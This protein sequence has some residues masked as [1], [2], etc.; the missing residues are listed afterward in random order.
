MS[1]QIP[2]RTY[3]YPDGNGKK[4]HIAVK[5]LRTPRAGDVVFARCGKVIRSIATTTTLLAGSEECASC[6]RNAGPVRE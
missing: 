1:E 3:V 6:K 5:S 2:T 4:W